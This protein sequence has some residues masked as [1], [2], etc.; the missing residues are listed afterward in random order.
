MDQGRGSRTMVQEMSEP[1]VSI[2][3]RLTR[4]YTGV[5]FAGNAG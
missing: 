4:A 2:H 3:Q 1:M 5:L